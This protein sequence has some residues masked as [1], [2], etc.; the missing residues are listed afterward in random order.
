MTKK[1]SRPAR[2]KAVEQE[3]RQLVTEYQAWLDALPENLAAGSIAGKLEET[4]EALE[5]IAD[6][7]DMIDPP[8]IGVRG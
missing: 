7:L 6:D 4:V 8:C 2:I 3:V 5:T 1:M